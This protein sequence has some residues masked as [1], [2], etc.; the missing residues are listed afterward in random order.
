MKLPLF[1]PNYD[2]VKIFENVPKLTLEKIFYFKFLDMED[3]VMVDL[4][5]IQAEIDLQDSLIESTQNVR[6]FKPLMQKIVES[7]KNKKIK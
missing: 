1:F 7:R 6:Y 5:A 4:N 2:S 3:E